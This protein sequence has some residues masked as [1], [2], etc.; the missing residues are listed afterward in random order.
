MPCQPHAPAPVDAAFAGPPGVPPAAGPAFT[1]LPPPAVAPLA[2]AAPPA[3]P[4]GP[5]DPAS[6]PP[7]AW[8][9]SAA[10]PAD[11]GK[12]PAWTLPALFLPFL[13]GE[14]TRRSATASTAATNGRYAFVV[15]MT[16]PNVTSRS[17]RK[18]PP[19]RPSR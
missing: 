18:Q 11:P 16:S 2:A 13:A 14:T 9:P 5:A 17:R 6:T 10:A 7:P 1:A 15:S 3:P 8:L 4:A 19:H 12:P